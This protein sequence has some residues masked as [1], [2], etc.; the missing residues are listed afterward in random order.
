[1]QILIIVWLA[2]LGACFG[3]FA[4][5]VA[6]R[7]YKAKDFVRDRSE[8]EHCQHKL[9]VWDLVPILSWLLLA[10][11]CRYCKKPI[12]WFALVVEVVSAL[13]FVLSYLAWP[14][15]FDST[16]GI[17]LFGLWIVSLVLMMILFV[18]DLRWKLLPNSVM[19]PLVLLGIPFFVG[20]QL[21]AGTPLVQWPIE[22]GLA[23]LPI[24]GFYWALYVLSRQRWVGMGDVK[25]GVFMGLVLP[26]QSG[27]AALFLANLIGTLY[28]VPLLA[29]GRVKRTAHV[30]FGPFLIVATV[31]ALLWGE[32]LVGWYM[33]VLGL[34]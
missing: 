16:I 3:S 25:F 11:R 20:R 24:T 15:G 27:V 19:L 6:W 33:S 23:M 32:A 4:G 2:V 28:I 9:S 10:G 7:L 30:P 1:M 13:L 8:C 12:G 21:A 22:L 18:Y 29:R 17:V 26:W 5:A 34:S 14:Y 31:L